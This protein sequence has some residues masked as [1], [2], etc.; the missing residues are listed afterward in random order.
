MNTRCFPYLLPLLTTGKYSMNTNMAL[1]K[2]NKDLPNFA[3]RGNNI[4]HT[5]KLVLGFKPRAI[6]RITC[7]GSSKT[8]DLR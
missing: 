8:S 4:G 3:R 6:Q 1:W 7:R 5:E 2:L